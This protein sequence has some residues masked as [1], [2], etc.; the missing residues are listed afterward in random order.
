MSKNRSPYQY[1]DNSRES[2]IIHCVATIIRW[3]LIISL[4]Y[5][6]LNYKMKEISQ[7]FT[8]KENKDVPK[9]H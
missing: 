2:F 4:L 5:L 3:L 7:S 1:D 9:A 8:L 6:F